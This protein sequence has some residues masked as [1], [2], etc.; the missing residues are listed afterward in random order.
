MSGSR[1][2]RALAQEGVSEGIARNERPRPSAEPR[3]Y[4]WLPNALPAMM[5]QSD[6]GDCGFL[7]TWGLRDPDQKR[8]PHF[9]RGPWIDLLNFVCLLFLVWWRMGPILKFRTS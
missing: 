4:D 5:G 9:D 2:E 7:T 8:G 1:A 6:V 3:S